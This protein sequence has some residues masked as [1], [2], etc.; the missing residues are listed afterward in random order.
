MR[1][2]LWIK[3][4]LRSRNDGKML[5]FLKRTGQE[6]YGTFWSTIEVLDYQNDNTLPLSGPEFEG[7][8]ESFFLT[9]ERY[10]TIINFA[11]DAG[12]F[13]SDGTRFWQERLKRD[14]VEAST[15]LAEASRANSATKVLAGRIGGLSKSARKLGL[16]GEE[17]QGFI[18]SKLAEASKASKRDKIDKI[19]SIS[20]KVDIDPP[21]PLKPCLVL[22]GKNYLSMTTEQW[23]K[24]VEHF[25]E[26]LLRQELPEA[27]EWISESDKASARKYR[28]PG[29]NHYLFFRSTWL[30]DKNIKNGSISNGH[31]RTLTKGAELQLRSFELVKKFEAEEKLAR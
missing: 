5:W 24:L 6:G 15:K 9:P 1:K 4:D 3:H 31:Q 7:T 19:D 26:P 11:I 20:T 28:R 8:A 16:K 22:Y 13:V 18:S 17:I 27:D 25:G 14:S 30:R 2:Q 29:Y 10:K 23:A 12:L 21:T